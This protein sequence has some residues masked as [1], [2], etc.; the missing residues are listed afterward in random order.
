MKRLYNI[1]PVG[2]NRPAPIV[3]KEVLHLFRS[4]FKYSILDLTRLLCCQRDWI[5]DN[6]LPDVLH[7][8]LNR[9]FRDYVIQQA[10]DLTESE[11]LT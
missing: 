9:F 1:K 8:H 5:E 11:F 3:A 7:I 4:E 10:N 2:K 6:L